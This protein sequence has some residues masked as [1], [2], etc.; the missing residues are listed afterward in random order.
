MGQGAPAR[1]QLTS[2]GL[3]RKRLSNICIRD[4]LTFAP[5][6]E[7]PESLHAA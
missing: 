4:T 7:L 2:P 5:A 6:A 3:L 1:V